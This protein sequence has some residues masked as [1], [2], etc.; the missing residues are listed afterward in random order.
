VPKKKIYGVKVQSVAGIEVCPDGVEDYIVVLELP[1]KQMFNL[2]LTPAVFA[3]LEAM[4]AE[5]NTLLAQSL[6]K[7]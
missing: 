6:A 4:I 5:A 2:H 1:E 7:Q 3:Q